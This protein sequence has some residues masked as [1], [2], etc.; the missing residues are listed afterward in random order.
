MVFR[1]EPASFH[2]RFLLALGFDPIH[3][4]TLYKILLKLGCW[5]KSWLS[6]PPCALYFLSP[7][8]PELWFS[9]WRQFSWDT[10]PELSFCLSPGQPQPHPLSYHVSNKN[11]YLQLLV[12]F[13]HSFQALHIQ[14]SRS[15]LLKCVFFL[16]P[17]KMKQLLTSY[18]SQKCDR[19]SRFFFL[20]LI[21]HQISSKF[22]TILVP[23][24]FFLNLYFPLHP[25]ANFDLAL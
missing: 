8:P 1:N 18:P 15:S 10:H 4:F 25:E 3:C 23:N 11:I 13:T 17:K 12:I 21:P 19:Y 24:H 22:Y 6:S 14:N 20:P 9:T 5:D 2:C 16:L 7:H